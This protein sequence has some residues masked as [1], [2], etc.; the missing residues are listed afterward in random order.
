M[1]DSSLYSLLETGAAYGLLPVAFAQSAILHSDTL[2]ADPAAGALCGEAGDLDDARCLRLLVIGD[3]SA[4]GG[5]C[6]RI[7]ESL[8]PRLAFALAMRLRCRV[9]W[10]VIGGAGWTAARLD[11][12]LFGAGV[13]EADIA[14]VMIGTN[15]AV[16]LT[17][18]V[19]W[20]RDL[21]SLRGRLLGRGVRLLG[22]SG[23]PAMRS[24]PRLAWP[25]GPLLGRRARQL[26]AVLRAMVRA[27]PLAADRTV[28]HLP[29]PAPDRA[30]DLAAD[31]LHASA[32]GYALWASHLATTLADEWRALPSA[33][34]D[35]LQHERAGQQ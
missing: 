3:G 21:E 22:F 32:S 35:D 9:R 6:A 14:L 23:L 7:D 13:P 27:M 17:P 1:A 29:V 28:L 20:R 24:L 10:Q 5:G 25:L 15:D 26:D 11:R 34:A 2:Q 31:G 30:S 12:E 18:R 16:T 19:D 4:I 8:A 33:V